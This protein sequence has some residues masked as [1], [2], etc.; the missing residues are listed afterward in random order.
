M[1]V[2]TTEFQS[3]LPC[4]DAQQPECG[5]K[6]VESPAVRIGADSIAINTPLCDKFNIEVNVEE[7]V[8][9][10]AT[11]CLRSY[12]EELARRF[13]NG[14]DPDAIKN[15]DTA[16]MKPPKGWFVVSRVG[17][18]AVGCGALKRLDAGIGEIKRVWVSPDTRGKGV[19]G[20]I[21]DQLER[22]AAA[23]GLATVRLDTNRTLFEACAFYAKRGYREID[24]Y[25]DNTYADFWFEKT[26]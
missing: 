14:F 16:D 17:G 21:M 8:T 19:A 7:P 26:L 20:R 10:D 1:P 2:A 4:V 18:R 5:D 22:I 23:E 13:E 25:N 15:F 9:P 6:P 3:C 12:Y 11:F 24:C